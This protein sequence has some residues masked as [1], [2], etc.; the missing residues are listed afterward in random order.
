MWYVHCP[1]TEGQ[2]R[3]F[4]MDSTEKR[5][6]FGRALRA[7]RTAAGLSQTKLSVQIDKDQGIISDYEAGKTEPGVEAVVALEEA[8]S[9]EPGSL[10]RYLGWIPVN[11]AEAPEPPNVTLRGLS[12]DQLQ[13]LAQKFM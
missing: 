4:R 8:L 9:L 11:P 10:S 7:A 2:A 1:Y 3:R 13:I 6:R 5:K 12:N